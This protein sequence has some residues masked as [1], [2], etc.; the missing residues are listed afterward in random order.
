MR[1]ELS[2][3]VGGGMGSGAGDV[4]GSRGE[5]VLE[6][7]DTFGCGDGVL[8]RPDSRSSA[9]AAARAS[10]SAEMR[11]AAIDRAVSTAS[12]SGVSGVRSGGTGGGEAGVRASSLS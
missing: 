8:V 10:A 3:V 7:G 12:L 6:D 11:R 1:G 9:F 5:E 2:L 4:V